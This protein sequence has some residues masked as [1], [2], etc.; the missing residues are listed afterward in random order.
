[1]LSLENNFNEFGD[2]TAY[3]I[4]IVF[5]R[6]VANEWELEQVISDFKIFRTEHQQLFTTEINALILKTANA[7]ASSFSGKN[8]SE[9]VLISELTFILNG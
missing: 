4:E 2:D 8:K 9:Q 3:E 5:D 1:M 7:I 6:L